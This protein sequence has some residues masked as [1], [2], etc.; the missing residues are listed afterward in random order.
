MRAH[1]DAANRDA[2]N[3]EV[4]WS[5]D[6]PL[7]AALMEE[8]RELLARLCDDQLCDEPLT[9]GGQFSGG[10]R[11]RLNEILDTH[12]A[13]RRYYLK[14]VAIHSSLSAM[15]GS[16]SA[17]DAQLAVERITL[18]R[19]AGRTGPP[20][21]PC[22]IEPLQL[23]RRERWQSVLRWSAGISAVVAL[24]MAGWW[25]TVRERKDALLAEAVLDGNLKPAVDVSFGSQPFG[26]QPLAAEVTYVSNAAVWQNP[27]GSFTLASR[28]RAGE[29]LTLERGQVELTYSTGA[30]LLLTGP[31][32]FLVLPAGGKLRRG[33]LVARVPQA[34][35]GFTIETPHGKVIDLGTEFGVVVDDFGVSQVSVF[36]GKVETLPSGPAGLAQ[37]KIELTSGRA[38]QWTADSVTPISVQGRRYGRPEESWPAGDEATTATSQPL[39]DVDFR[40]RELQA[41][42][43]KTYGELVASQRGLRLQGAAV[44]RPYLIA[45]QELD[46]VAGPVNVVCDLRFESVDDAEHASFAILT[47]S[48]DAQSKSG[49][50]W[51]DMLSRSVRCRLMAD[52]LSGEGL[53]EAGTKYEADR[54]HTNISW[55]GFSQPRP[56]TLYRLEMRDDGLNVSFTVSLVENPSV[57]KTITCRSLFRGNQNFVALEGPSLGTATVERLV[58]TQDGL[59]GRNS[60][61]A[62]SA[63]DKSQSVSGA[64]EELAQQLDELIPAD[65]QLVVRDSFDADEVD[66]KVWKTL[67]DVAVDDGEVQLGVP[68]NEQ[69]IDTWKARPYLLTRQEF[70]PADGALTIVGKVTFSENFL[71][72]YGGSFAVMTRADDTHG[73]GPAW[74]NSILRRGVRS[75][76]WPAAYGFDHSLEI[77]E[78]PE[79][80]TISLLVAEAFPIAP[81]SRS[82][83]FRIV[84]DGSAATLTFL[85]ARDPETRKTVSHATSAAM[86]R[87][88]HIG[89]ESCWGSPLRLDEVRIYRGGEPSE[90]R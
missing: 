72:G 32:E 15:A 27:N 89:F 85:D 68:N 82:Y 41:G 49:T 64:P 13:A 12:A 21:A 24:A 63:F 25:L 60:T 17:A 81:S 87:S 34:G 52:L 58:V 45:A 30:K 7:N 28:V 26:N 38:I 36:E 23:E 84:D 67:G 69:H 14:Y 56:G 79:P 55:G 43:W 86:L 22:G 11:A 39:L 53:L 83:L 29:N 73:G 8:L 20:L 46:P 75:N 54:E 65:A 19:F 16:A 90:F 57:R 6:P 66:A 48:S 10:D 31:S 70:D 2:A 5:A 50:P 78:K 80:N 44:G 40:G 3:R 51:Q 76:F 59:Q 62:F 74:E 42:N 4:D 35:H 37:D 33:E 47:R 71:H 1:D 9:G 61:L 88:G 77:H 18:E